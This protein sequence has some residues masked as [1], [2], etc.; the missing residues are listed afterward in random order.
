MHTTT[1]S[2][3][4]AREVALT[5]LQAAREEFER[6]ARAISGQALAYRPPGDD[7]ALGGLVVHVADVA[8]RYTRLLDQVHASGIAPLRESEHTAQ[9]AALVR[10][11]IGARP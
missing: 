8:A 3:R 6:T 10:R 11:G 7:F 4:A 9:I 1:H 5:A 2:P